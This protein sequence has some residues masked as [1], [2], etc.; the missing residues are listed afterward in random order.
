MLEM[1]RGSLVGILFGA[2]VAGGACARPF[3]PPP[4]PEPGP[5]VAGAPSDTLAMLRAVAALWS[6]ED[7]REASDTGG[8]ALSVRLC[9]LSEP[10]RDCTRPAPPD[11]WY[12]VPTPTVRSLAALAGIPL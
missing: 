1:S 3:S 9:Q 2:L 10:R 4:P 11:T 6:R 5:G 8:R 12:A 7:Q